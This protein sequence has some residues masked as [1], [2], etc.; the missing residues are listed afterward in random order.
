MSLTIDPK[1]TAIV[2][3]DFEN[4]IVNSTQNVEPV[5]DN[6]RQV[7]EAGREVH[8]PVIFIK[9]CFDSKYRDTP[10]NSPLFQMVKKKGILRA[11]TTGTEIHSMLRP[12]PDEPVLTK[13]CT[14]AFLTSNLQQRLNGLGVDTL[15]V[16]GLWTNY[17]VE[18]TVRHA[19]DMGYRVI[20][21]KDAC[22]SNTV[23]NHEFT[24]NNIMP[25]LALV[26]SAEDVLQALGVQPKP[27]HKNT[28]YAETELDARGASVQRVVVK[29]GGRVDS[30]THHKTTEVYCVVRGSAKMAIGDKEYAATPGSVFMARPGERHSVETIGDED[31]ELVMFTTNQEPTDVYVG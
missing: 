27:F 24:I 13:T 4:D 28:L 5:L 31:F 25:T 15:I 12:L 16:M 3:L 1:R 20:V 19:S 9:V 17:A 11:G 30:H 14:N 7:V 22:A 23:E 6:A 18:S 8:L 21:V 2:A 10:R 29:P 26:N